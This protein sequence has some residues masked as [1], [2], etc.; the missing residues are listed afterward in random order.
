M[1]DQVYCFQANKSQSFLIA[2]TTGFGGDS[3]T[4]SKHRKEPAFDTS[5]IAQERDE[6]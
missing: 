4:W 5:A 1:R 6:K 3:Q 2:H